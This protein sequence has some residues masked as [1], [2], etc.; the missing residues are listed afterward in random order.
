MEL[1]KLTSQDILEAHAA[2]RART[3]LGVCGGGLLG[4]GE[5]NIDA[6]LGLSAMR[7]SYLES[8]DGDPVLM[9]AAALLRSLATRHSFMD[10]N[11]RAAWLACVAALKLNGYDLNCTD[12]DGFRLAV[13]VVT[14][15]LEPEVIAEQLA[16]WLTICEAPSR[17]DVS[18]GP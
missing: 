5:Q 9:Y 12:E 4:D 14:E 17:S 15:H 3:D 18:P 6:A 2:V 1:K 16:D 7:V 8:D 10:G 11:K 13:R